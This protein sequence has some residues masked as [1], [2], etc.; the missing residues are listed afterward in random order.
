MKS[1]GLSYFLCVLQ[2]FTG[3]SGIHRFYLG[4]PL[5]GVLYLLTWGFFGIATIIDLIRMPEIVDTTNFKYL[6]RNKKLML[7]EKSHFERFSSPERQIL[8]IAKKHGDIITVQMVS[9]ESNLSLNQAK[10]E[11]EKLKTS[12]FCTKDVDEAGA[13]IYTFAGF[14]AQK[15]LLG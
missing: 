2:F 6:T 11:L 1:L 9:L 3:I 10:H 5:S 7:V 15:P 8:K 4:K 12:G 13:E 14:E